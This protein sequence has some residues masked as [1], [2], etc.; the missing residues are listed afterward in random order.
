M[1]LT[2]LKGTV[3]ACS[4][5]FSGATLA[6]SPSA[7]MLSNTCFGCHGPNGNSVGPAIPSIAGMAETYLVDVMN[8]YKEG[9][10]GSTIMTRIAKGYSA[11]EIESMSA[12]F[13][14]QKYAP[15]TQ[16]ADAGKAK[17]GAKLHDKYC[18]KCH[19]EAGTL[20]DDEA[21]FLAGQWTPYLKA[22]LTDVMAGTRDVPKKMTKALDKAKKKG[23]DDAIDQ[24]LHFYASYK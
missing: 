8:Q 12:W 17:A 2:A 6:D 4:L 15:A 22:S 21:G 14:S 5:A 16:M 23:G 7:E 18:D 13:A 9:A 20:A 10:R 19:S 1:Q 11:E 24:L 3:L